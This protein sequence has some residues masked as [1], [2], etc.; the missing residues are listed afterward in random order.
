MKVESTR[1]SD[2]KLIELDTYVDERGYFSE[3]WNKERYSDYGIHEEFVQDNLSYSNK[4][5]LRGL[6]FQNPNAQGKLVSVLD[7]EVYDVAVD[8]RLDSPTFSQWV[9]VNLSS[10]NRR[11]LYVPPGYAHGF[12]VTSDHALF[13]YKCT[14]RYNSQAEHCIHWND[15]DINISWPII[16]P[17]VSPKDEQGLK[18]LK[19]NEQDLPNY[20][21]QDLYKLTGS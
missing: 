20:E 5:V 19:M 6:H 14:D 12:C 11:Q 18:L 10:S 3:T 16:N 4:G 17:V 2:V 8:I 15:P 1:L 9:G 7:G 13:S 21:P